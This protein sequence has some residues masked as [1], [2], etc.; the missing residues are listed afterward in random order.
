[1]PTLVP[2]PGAAN[3]NTYADLTYYK[4]FVATRRPRP[5]WAAL[6]TGSTVDNDLTIDLLAAAKLLDA[7][8]VWTGQPADELQSL[9]APRI[10]WRNRSSALI[11][12]SVIPTGMKDAQCELAVQLHDS[13]VVTEDEAGKANVRRVKADTLEVEFQSRSDSLEA[14]SAALRRQESQFMYLS[15]PIKVRMYLVPSWYV[16]AEMTKGLIFEVL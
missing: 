14:T 9:I 4:A 7:G 6:A 13:D 15:M 1:M 2:T 11:D 12:P 16:Q 3:A 10:G 8:F 5:L